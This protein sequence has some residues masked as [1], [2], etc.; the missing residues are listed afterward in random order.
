MF[1]RSS[2]IYLPG[3][4]HWLWALSWV[5]A[6]ILSSQ[7]LL[8][9]AYISV[10]HLLEWRT[11]AYTEQGSVKSCYLL[12]SCTGHT[13]LLACFGKGPQP[14]T[15]RHG[16][17][18]CHCIHRISRWFCCL[19]RKGSLLETMGEEQFMQMFL[20]IRNVIN[21]G[22]ENLPFSFISL[23]YGMTSFV[24]QSTSDILLPC[25]TLVIHT[26]SWLSQLILGCWWSTAMPALMALSHAA[27][28][29]LVL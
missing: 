28:F 6:L 5:S 15:F 22:E 8:Y 23:Y 1:K 10:S 3:T 29:S 21:K 16:G 19:L 9:I 4:A 26:S 7:P 24:M 11:G 14:Q 2:G 18:W 13:G 12:S 27:Q 20:I 17:R 25:W